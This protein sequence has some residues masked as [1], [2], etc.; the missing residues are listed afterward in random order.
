VKLDVR[1]EFLNDVLAARKFVFLLKYI[2][3]SRV[4]VKSGLRVCFK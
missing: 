2:S 4:K 3:A 1:I